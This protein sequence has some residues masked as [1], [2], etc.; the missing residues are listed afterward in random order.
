VLVVS[1][2]DGP[3]GV[4]ALLGARGCT[5]DRLH[6]QTGLL[7]GRLRAITERAMLAAAMVAREL[8]TS[9]PGASLVTSV[10][11]A[12]DGLVLPTSRL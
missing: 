8:S 12:N 5:T 6:G 10:P 3:A 4:H 2:D 9:W 1:P 7:V 11:N